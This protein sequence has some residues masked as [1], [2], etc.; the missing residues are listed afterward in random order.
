MK[1][2]FISLMRF[3]MKRLKTAD[4]NIFIHFIYPLL[5][6]RVIE[7]NFSTSDTAILNSAGGMIVT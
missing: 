4:P 1:E 6:L 7:I 5:Y 2:L 3:Q